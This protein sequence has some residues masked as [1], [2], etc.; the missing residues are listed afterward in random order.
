MPGIPTRAVASAAAAA[1]ALLLAGCGSDDAQAGAADGVG[2]VAAFY[3]LQWAAERV[4]GDRVDVTSLT[5]P[6]AEPHD[7]ELTPQDVATL[8]GTDLLVYLEGFQPALDDAAAEAGD[9]AWDAGQ[10]ADLSLTT[11]AHEHE[12]ETEEEHAEHADEEVPDPHF[13]LDPTRLADVGDALAD[14]L[15]EV[16]PDGA[17]TFRDNAAALRTDLEAL[18]AEMAQ[19]LSDCASTTMVT[20]HEAFGYLADRYGLDV[21]GISGLSPSAEP[22]P[23]QLAE[24]S[25]LV[26]ERGVTTVYTET[27]VDPAVAETVA[28]EAGVQTA[29]L[30]PLEGLT[31]ES[32]GSD[33]LE[34]MRADLAT[35]REGQGCA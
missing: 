12:G 8:S 31:D 5:P 35:L 11:E 21:V 19:G 33:Y 9:A 2:V 18:D 32:A 16:D 10:A 30:D 6:G 25:T 22:D 7:L 20:S 13:W 17:A 29:V 24:I 3:P 23:A 1:S 28:E 14:R 27:L 26:Q 34:V 4:G 15:A